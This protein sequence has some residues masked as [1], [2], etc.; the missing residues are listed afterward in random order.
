MA[1]YICNPVNIDYRYQFSKPPH[2]AGKLSIYREA[3]DPSMIFFQGKY[4]IFASMTLSVWVSDDLAH[5]ERHPLPSDLPLYD[6]A[7]DVRVIRLPEKVGDSDNTHM[8]EWVYFCASRMRKK[9]DRFRT[10]DILNGPYEKIK[11]TFDYWDPNLFQDD[12]GRL[13][14]YWG[15]SNTEPI[16]GV[17]LDPATMKPVGATRS[18]P[19]GN[20]KELISG[21]PY[22]KGYERTG[23]DHEFLPA[24]E[25][26]V[27]KGYHEFA[28]KLHIPEFIIPKGLRPMIRGLYTRTP[29]IEGPWMTKHGSKYY[30]QYACP[31]AECNTYADG[32]YI[33][34]SPL[35]PFVPAKNNPFSYKPG[36]FLP[37]AGHGSTMEDPRGCLWHTSTMRISVNYNFERR[38]GIWPA[39]FT[40]DDELVCD[41]RYG[42]WP[43]RLPDRVRIH[44]SDEWLWQDPEWMLLSYAKKTEASS[45]T[46]GC[47][48]ENAVDENVQTWWRARSNSR[49]EWL[50]VDLG[51]VFDVRAVQINFADDTINIPVPGRIHPG[52]HAR[53]IDKR[54]YATQW[55]LSGS[56]DGENY[57]IL[58]DKSTAPTDLSHDLVLMEEGKRI[59]YLKLWNMQVPYDQNPAISGLRVFG[60]P[61]DNQI[62]QPAP[63]EFTLEKLGPTDVEVQMVPPSDWVV[64]YNILFGYAPEKL[65]HSHMVMSGELKNSDYR[66]RIGALVAGDPCYVQVDSFNE[67]GVTHGICKM[68]IYESDNQRLDN[69]CLPQN[70]ERN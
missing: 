47:G 44:C 49:D 20:Y 55:I 61:I 38:V 6:Y 56:E 9:C 39:G 3:A 15:C 11:G 59:R 4:Y 67:A 23:K 52:I 12:D 18:C 43:M 1:D 63:A 64:G 57:F 2:E 13:Y 65:F 24:T 33:A 26:E 37:G 40:V 19:K 62:K 41:Q 60:Q 35:G 34:D 50:K 48:S 58:M 5:W 8:V 25:E 10:K 30:L 16:Y 29:Y 14:F 22:V 53:H 17:E 45:F 31:S 28:K 51:S 42:D 69:L 46:K 70:S 32:V 68:V 66:K 54:V 36:G 21:D 27:Q 7:P